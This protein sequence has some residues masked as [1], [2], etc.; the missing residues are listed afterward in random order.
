MTLLEYPTLPRDFVDK[1]AQLVKISK[2]ELPSFADCLD[3]LF[4]MAREWHARDREIARKQ[5][6]VPGE[7]DDVRKLAIK[8]RRRLLT[9]D[10]VSRR[11]LGLYALVQ[12]QLPYANTPGADVG[13]MIPH[14]VKE[15]DI[16]QA[17]RVVA[18]YRI[19]IDE[20]IAAAS[21]REWPVREGR[22]ANWFDYSQDTNMIAFD[23][24]VLYFVQL[25][26]SHG[27]KETLEKNAGTGSLVDCLKLARAHL[28]AGLITNGY[29]M[30]RLERLRRAA[31]Q[32]FPR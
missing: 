17:E 32:G 3:A 27:G 1:V 14:L 22:P 18:S 9:L 4:D 15:G 24:F 16:E 31:R 10:S 26:R 12:Q 2:E 8:L 25:I 30:S 11:H 5:K 6:V 20:M 23:Y 21:T 29:S 19:V 7:L 13:Q 28:P